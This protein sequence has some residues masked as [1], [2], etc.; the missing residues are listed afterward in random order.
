MLRGYYKHSI[1]RY[2][3][4]EDAKVIIMGRVSRQERRIPLTPMGVLAPGSSH[5]RPS[6]QPPINVSGTFP[7]HMSAESK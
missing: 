6:A 5:A 4:Q 1:S 2:Q 3:K 7:A